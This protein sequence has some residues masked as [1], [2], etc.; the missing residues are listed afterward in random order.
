MKEAFPN[1]SSQ[2]KLVDETFYKN[3]LLLGV[4]ATICFVQISSWLCA[5]QV[6]FGRVRACAF[7]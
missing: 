6:G 1:Q 7:A 5:I 2:F 3:G 4:M